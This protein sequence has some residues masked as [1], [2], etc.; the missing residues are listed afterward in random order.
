MS[1]SH[2]RATAKILLSLHNI[3]RFVFENWK[4]HNFF[5][6]PIRVVHFYP[7]YVHVKDFIAQFPAQIFNNYS[8]DAAKKYTFIMS[9]LRLIIYRW[10]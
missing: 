10:V 2:R 7:L 4:I 9:D 5:H 1:P 6:F 8:C 3:L